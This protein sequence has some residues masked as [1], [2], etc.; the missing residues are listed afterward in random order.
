MANCKMS[1]KGAQCATVAAE[2]DEVVFTLPKA[3]ADEF[4]DD[5]ITFNVSPRKRVQKRALVDVSNSPAQV[6]GAR[7]PARACISAGNRHLHTQCPYTHTHT[8]THT[9]VHST[10]S[11]MPSRISAFRI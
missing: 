2:D 4:C 9:K 11:H 5:E 6:E 8:H 10:Y 1:T 7:K 3:N